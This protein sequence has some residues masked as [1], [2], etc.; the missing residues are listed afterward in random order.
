[1]AVGLNGTEIG[2][3]N[4]SSSTD[5]DLI[6]EMFNVA[7]PVVATSISLT[8]TKRCYV[9][10]ITVYYEGEVSGPVS[11]TYT[12]VPENVKLTV[13]DTMEYPAIEPSDLTYTFSAEPAGILT[14]DDATKTITA[15]GI[16]KATVKFT[17][18]AVGDYEAGQGSFEVEVVS[19]ATAS[20]ND[21][22]V[23]FSEL[24]YA[25]AAAVTDVKV[26]DNISL[27]CTKGSGSNAPAYY[28]S[29]AALRMYANNTMTVKAASGYEITNITFT[30]VSGY[31]VKGSVDVGTLTNQSNTSSSWTGN[32]S[33]I[34]FTNNTS[35]QWRITKIEISYT[36]TAPKD[37]EDVEISE[38]IENGEAVITLACATEGATIKYGFAE[39]AMTNVY[40]APFTVSEKCTVYAQAEKNGQT[41]AISKKEI[42]LPT[43]FTSLK[44]MVNKSVN[45]ES[46]T[47]IGNFSVIYQSSD[48][49]YLLV[50]DGISN[51]LVYNPG[52]A[53]EVGTKFSQL[54][55]ACQIY[56][57]LFELTN[58][59]LTEGGQGAAYTPMAITDLSAINIDSNI[60]DEVTMT[61]ATVSGV[62][63]KN[64]TLTLNGN[65]LALYNTFGISLENTDNATVTGF[66]WRYNNNLQLSP[67]SIEGKIVPVIANPVFE[68]A[69]S[70]LSVGDKISITCETEGVNIYYTTDG[71]DPTETSTLYT[72]PIEFREAV[73]I[74][75]RAYSANADVEMVP[76]EIVEAVYTLYNPNKPVDTVVTF[77]F[78][79]TD[80]LV[81]IF[82]SDFEVPATGAG[83]NITEPFTKDNIT[84]TATKNSSN[85]PRIWNTKGVY[86]LRAYASDS[87]TIAAPATYYIKKIEISADKPA[88]VSSANYTSGVW[89]TPAN[90]KE[91]EVSFNV[92][93]SIQISSITVS[94]A[95]KDQETG[96]EEITTE[97]GE[98]RYYDLNG[99]EVKGQ[100]EN[101]IYVRVQN[102]KATKVLVK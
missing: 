10:S 102:G 26:D 48:N 4:T 17:T 35:S 39:D 8:A 44:E 86:T 79:T 89:E 6:K 41:S 63:G 77:D 11:P 5:T 74:K 30:T 38:V 21:V 55:G 82:G 47:A 12:N 90:S 84:I 101:G 25:N 16:G 69:S 14:L 2:K 46:I 7:D 29:G 98:V 13:G 85:G 40:S 94:I 93:G 37:V 36:T 97:D 71:T 67:I 96:V 87:F 28:T 52:K 62:S 57:G 59:T 9:K 70:E 91:S 65:T 80:G 68:P 23:T 43:K 15:A 73:T 78:S 42:D 34:L 58:A 81:A 83:Y 99:R 72:A 64:A 33:S 56:N 61:G 27:V 75:A 95:A 51:A 50:T 45:G 24:G 20:G 22:T 54:M 32:A 18:P 60:F 88:N 76:S 19:P 1:M 31:A 66:V 92:T 100:L 49:K 3:A 53:Y